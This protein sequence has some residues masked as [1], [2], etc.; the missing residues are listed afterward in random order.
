MRRKKGKKS[1]PTCGGKRKRKS[2]KG[3]PAPHAESKEKRIGRKRSREEVGNRKMKSKDRGRQT[4]RSRG[5]KSIPGSPNLNLFFLS[6]RYRERRTKIESGE[7]KGFIISRTLSVLG[8][9][10]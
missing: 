7:H 8:E 6:L 2:D 3:D 10:M 4:Y 1:P 9:K 5:R